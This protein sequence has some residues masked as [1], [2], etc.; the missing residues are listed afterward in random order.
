M[1]YEVE[2]YEDGYEVVRK[3]TRETYARFPNLKGES[4][5][6]TERRAELYAT[7]LIR[8]EQ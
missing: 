7:A 4:Y 1:R 3:S 5:S 6:A 2:S 8:D